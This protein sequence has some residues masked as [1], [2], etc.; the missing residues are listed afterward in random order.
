MLSCRLAGPALETWDLVAGA[1]PT[2]PFPQG[3][4]LCLNRQGGG[5]EGSL[6]RPLPAFS[7]RALSRASSHRSPLSPGPQTTHFQGGRRGALGWGVVRGAWIG[8]VQGGIFPVSESEHQSTALQP[9]PPPPLPPSPSTCALRPE[10]PCLYPHPPGSRPA[11]RGMLH[12]NKKSHPGDSLS[13]GGWEAQK[14]PSVSGYLSLH[15]ATPSAGFQGPLLR[16]PPSPPPNS[17]R[18]GNRFMAVAQPLP[19]SQPGGGEGR[20]REPG[21]RPH[22]PHSPAGKATPPRP[23][24]AGTPLPLRAAGSQSRRPIAGARSPWAMAP[25]LVPLSRPPGHDRWAAEQLFLSR[26]TRVQARLTPC[27]P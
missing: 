25:W 14:S 10:E 18:C 19:P 9:P 3:P 22:P 2:P 20:G 6:S 5:C 17:L 16:H 8:G 21:R 1:F 13:P 26:D 23:P 27:A 11:A 12:G 4:W 7:P 15:S 24:P